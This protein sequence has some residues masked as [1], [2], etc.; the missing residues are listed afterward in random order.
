MSPIDPKLIALQFNEY[1]NHQ[2]VNGISNL[3]TEDYR[4]IDRDGNGAIVNNSSVDGKRAF[5]WDPV[6]SAA[7][8]GVIGLTKS[9]AMQYADKGLR[10]N[11]ICPGWIKTPP[12]EDMIAHDPQAEGRML[13]HQPIGKSVV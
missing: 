12:V 4:F 11:A 3:M 6:Y 1:I 8:H 7:K 9:A 5:P 10:I 2:N 13:V